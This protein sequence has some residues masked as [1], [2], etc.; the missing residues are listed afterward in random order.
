M[1][2]LEL[3]HSLFMCGEIGSERFNNL[4]RPEFQWQSGSA[5]LFRPFSVDL[6]AVPRCQS[7]SPLPHLSCA[8]IFRKFKV[9]DGSNITYFLGQA[10]FQ[11]FISALPPHLTVPR[12]QPTPPLTFYGCLT[13]EFVKRWPS[14][15]TVKP[16]F[17]QL[18]DL[19]VTQLL[20][21]SST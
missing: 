2:Y 21:L 8:F 17:S 11:A 7:S 12:G 4:F 18:R 13:K 6:P 19:Q 15:S 3:L 9:L 5:L 14:Q 10:F 1:R 20:F 16:N